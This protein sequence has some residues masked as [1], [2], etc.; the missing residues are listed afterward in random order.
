[1]N[2]RIIILGV[3]LY[4]LLINETFS[5]LKGDARKNIL[6]L[7]STDCFLNNKDR[8]CMGTILFHR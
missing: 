6:Y 8:F 5:M 4:I 2:K 7:I 1:M 3:K